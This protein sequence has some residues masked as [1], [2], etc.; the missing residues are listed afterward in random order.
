ML[1]CLALAIYFEAQGEP[2]IGQVAVGQTILNRVADPRWPDNTCE[3]IYQGP[4]DSRGNM[5]RHKCQFSFYCDGRPD[6]PQ[7]GAAWDQA[8]HNAH[9]AVTLHR[10]GVD[11]TAG[12]THYHADYVSPGWAERLRRLF[13]IGRHIFY[14]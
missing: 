13:Q 12:A 4:R 5:V 2:D 11:V 1:E 10:V 9:M 14:R 7:P 3:V 8:Q 6:Q